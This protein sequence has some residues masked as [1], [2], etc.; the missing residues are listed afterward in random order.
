MY[1][2]KEIKLN[3]KIEKGEGTPYQ[4]VCKQSGMTIGCYSKKEAKQLKDNWD[5]WEFADLYSKVGLDTLGIKE[6]DIVKFWTKPHGK[7]YT[8]EV[9]IDMLNV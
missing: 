5:S 3:F 1:I 8:E 7:N 6:N 2:T 4:V 9:V